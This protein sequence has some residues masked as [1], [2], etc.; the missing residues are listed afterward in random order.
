MK[1]QLQTA[2]D[3]YLERFQ[4]DETVNASFKKL[5]LENVGLQSQ[6]TPILHRFLDIAQHQ[7]YAYSTALGYAMMFFI[8]W[9]ED[10]DQAIAYNEKAR[11]LF[12]QQ[13]DYQEKEGI[14]TVANNAVLAYILKEDYGAAYQEI[15]WAMP[16]AEK[17][18]RISYYSAFLNN[19]SIILSEFGLY[20][21]AIQQVEETLQKREF[22]GESN[23]FT[24]VFQLANLYLRAKETKKLRALF[25][26]HMSELQNTKMY[27]TT[28][29]YG[30]YMEAAMLENDRPMAD[31]YYHQ[32]MESYDFA[33]NDAIDN[34][35]IYLFLGRYHFYCKE[36]EQAQECYERILSHMDELLGQKRA[37]LEEAAAVYQ[38][39]QEHEKAYACLSQAHER[40][41]RYTAF[42]DD[43]YRKEVDDVWEKNRM[44]SYEVLYD[45]LLDIT[46]FGKTVTASLTWQELYDVVKERIP[47]MFCYDSCD[48]L[49]YDEPNQRFYSF[50]DQEYLL[51]DHTLL[52][53]CVLE[54]HAIRYGNISG[55]QWKE[56][57]GSLYHDNMHS[58]LLQPVIYREKLLGLYCMNDSQ[59]DNFGRT[60]Q[61]LLQVLSDY[62]AIALHNVQQFED[63][64]EKSSYDYLSGIYNRSALM[65]HGDVMLQDAKQKHHAIGALMMDIDD[66]K[67]I[68]DTYGH[69]QGDEVIRQVTAIIQK[70]NTHG[71]AARF[72]GE[73]FI[74]L[75]DQISQQELFEL[76]ERIRYACEVCVIPQP[77]GEI[78]F[79]ISI[80]GCYQRFA[81]DSLNELFRLAD[82]RLYVAK[83]NG[84]NCIQL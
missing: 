65:Q 37:V 8:T 79:T 66:F 4:K 21:K 57:L 69:M 19:G 32:L 17:Y 54:Q 84:K 35:E 58:L 16:M 73:E 1:E 64:L 81:N 34:S 68:N 70:Q 63:A 77:V 7:K 13:E 11:A 53:A 60:D 43:M 45:R 83:R 42:I 20:K 78:R 51:Q 33:N 3:E 38:A 31:S 75:I 62:T 23:Y 12:L 47:A 72:G 52:R 15:L 29:F 40:M 46:D 61:G 71:I 48:L 39:L 2:F 74:L 56:Q 76:A 50:D 80:G 9:Y 24:T 55:D 22:I 6:L 10:I 44:L 67:K 28:I 36:Y 41:I 26:E 49:L 59:L 18:G 25:T 82:Q 5:V 30:Q 14:L 27:S